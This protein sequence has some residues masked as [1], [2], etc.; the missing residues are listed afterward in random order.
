MGIKTTWSAFSVHSPKHADILQYKVL[1]P[2]NARG[3]SQAVFLT[4]N[5][6]LEA[7]KRSAYHW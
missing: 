3:A 7:S 6:A 5:E 1:L 4:H 2:E